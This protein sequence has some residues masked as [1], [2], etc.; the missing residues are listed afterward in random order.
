MSGELLATLSGAQPKWTR[1]EVNKAL[2]FQAPPPSGQ[3][4]KLVIDGRTLAGTHT[5]CDLGITGG[6]ADA[7]ELYAVVIQ[8]EALPIFIEACEGLQRIHVQDCKEIRCMKC[9]PDGVRVT[10]QALCV[11]LGLGPG[12][13]KDNRQSGNE[14][15]WVTAQ[16]LLQAPQQLLETLMCFDPDADPAG[17]IRLLDP[18][19][20]DDSGVFDP[21]SVVKA[22][23]VCAALCQWCHALHTYCRVAELG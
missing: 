9:P 20:Q 11:L 15:Y 13:I 10:M 17:I 2:Q 16:D 6:K 4:Y 21:Q 14:D 3:F 18:Y 19:V 22:S 7:F 1:A 8:N 5:L 12:K 23:I